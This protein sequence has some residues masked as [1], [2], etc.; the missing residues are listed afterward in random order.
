MQITHDT[1]AL[2]TKRRGWLV[3]AFLSGNVNAGGFL[4]C[5]QFVTHVTGFATFFGL[6][7]ARGN[8]ASAVGML[9]VPLV[10]LLGAVISG[11]LVDV[12]HANGRTPRRDWVMVMIFLSL[13][14]ATIGGESGFFGDFA[15]ATPQERDYILLSLLCFASGL[16]NAVV[17]SSTGAVIRTTHLTGLTTDLGIGLARAF[18]RRQQPRQQHHEVANNWV[19]G[20]LIT[21][22]IAGSAV[23]AWLFMRY[24]Y[25]GFLVPCVLALFA[26]R[27]GRPTP[28]N[29]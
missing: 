9:T 1:G 8:L 20:G 18:F 21:A 4:T 27:F 15:S 3:L 13:A 10:F 2:A 26:T 28:S 5:H 6:D 19:R 11:Y 22:Y 16:Q 14:L 25:H 7:L 24:H 29:H 17:T 12:R 23:G